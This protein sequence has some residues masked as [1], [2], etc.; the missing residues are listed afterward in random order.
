MP[1][2]Q[3]KT[4][5]Y[6]NKNI[7]KYTQTTNELK[8]KSQQVALIRGVSFVIGVFFLYYF[9]SQS[10][11][12]IATIGF[13]FITTFIFLL[14]KSKY[15]GE[16]K[17]FYLNLLNFNKNQKD[18]FIGKLSQYDEGKK[19]INTKHPYSYDMDLFGKK[20]VFQMLNRTC[21]TFGKEKLANW[22]NNI[23]LDID[24]INKRQKVI[25]YFKNKQDWV[26]N[27]I[28]KGN[29]QELDLDKNDIQ[30]LTKTKYR[31]TKKKIFFIQLIVLSA[32]TCTSLL[33]VIF[34][35]IPFNVFFFFYLIQFSII[36]FHLRKSNA[37]HNKISKK[38]QLFN[39]YEQLFSMLD[40]ITD[41][42]SDYFDKDAIKN[43]HIELKALKSI[44]K[45]YDHR[46]NLL[47][48]VIAQ[49]LFQWDSICNIRLEKWQKKNSKNIENWFKMIAELDALLSLSV[50]AFNHPDFCFPEPVN[51]AFY[52]KAKNAGH[53]FIPNNKRIGNDFLFDT[54]GEFK[55]I[56]GANMA[57]KSTFLRTVG[58]NLI[59]AGTGSVVCAQKF[60]YKPVL[61]YSS[62]RTEDSLQ[63]NESYFYAELK[64]LKSIIDRLKS[65]E[66]L[67]IIID[68]MLRG[69]NSRD[70]HSGSI[71]MIKQLTN[72]NAYGLFATHDI[73]I[74]EL[75]KNMPD[76]IKNICFEV[77]IKDN[78]LFFNYKLQKGISQNLNASFLMKKMGI[79]T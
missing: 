8:R 4:E 15:L 66:T 37:L 17:K 21:T 64:R 36:G 27:F 9:S 29:M 53:P 74:G 26:Q 69:T 79:M 52:I 6:Y 10:Y 78:K 16:Q 24:I 65:G 57:G 46:L 13:A 50:F 70:K 12:A 62:V 23:S 11:I 19:Y 28:A 68:E 44:T 77:E 55:I 22:L 41:S 3:K 20:S 1:D 2:S 31:F 73:S 58:L 33:M 71:G 30:N 39:K 40:E 61:I 59:L 34:N 7:N 18:Y 48:S 60:E 63:D 49:G 42:T 56:T 72:L 25:A 54:K 75:A 38:A 14:K 76:K 32:I 35:I 47:F 5:Q 67:F 43:I 45:S 51:Q